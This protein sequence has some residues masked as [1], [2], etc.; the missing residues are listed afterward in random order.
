ML[1]LSHSPRT[2]RWAMGDGPG[3]SR[4]NR[5]RGAPRGALAACRI[6]KGDVRATN[7][8][9]TYPVNGRLA[10]SRGARGEGRGAGARGEEG[11]AR[12]KAGGW[13]S[14]GFFRAPA[15]EREIPHPVSDRKV[16]VGNFV[17][18]TEP[19]SGPDPQGSDVDGRGASG[20]PGPGASPLGEHSMEATRSTG[21]PVSDPE[22]GSPLHGSW[23]K[24]GTW[25]GRP[26]T[27]NSWTG[28]ASTGFSV[29]LRQRLSRSEQPFVLTT[30]YNPMLAGCRTP[31]RLSGSKPR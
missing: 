14:L 24:S 23:P 1:R 9:V 25:S 15:S 12:L 2:P 19:P 11:D 3:R 30:V 26:S 17:G 20:S 4:A 28:T 7:W 29:Q 27:I 31:G 22:R 5:S 8:R 16:R 21:L 18:Q 10:R 6:D 13:Q